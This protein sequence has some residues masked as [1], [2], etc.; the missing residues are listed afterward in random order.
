M[1]EKA[2]QEEDPVCKSLREG[3][4][5]EAKLR[6]FQ[7]VPHQRREIGTIGMRPEGKEGADQGGG[8]TASRG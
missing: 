5:T 8:F 3:S 1:G 4:R 2:F 6:E 7:V